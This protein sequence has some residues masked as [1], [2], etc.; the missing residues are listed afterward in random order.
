MPR[1]EG[2][3]RAVMR[4]NTGR[5]AQV[6]GKTEAYVTQSVMGIFLVMFLTGT[7]VDA[8]LFGRGVLGMGMLPGLLDPN[9]AA[10][11]NA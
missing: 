5:G 10:V 8:T 2:F 11:R 9:V 3:S 1:L 4:V 7:G 6:A